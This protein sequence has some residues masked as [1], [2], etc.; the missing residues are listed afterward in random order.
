MSL[1]R[2]NPK[3]IDQTHIRMRALDELKPARRNARTH[4]ER[5]IEQIANSIT[6]FGFNNPILV[7]DQGNVMA[8]HGR[9]AAAELLGMAKVPT[10][11]ISHLSDDQKRA[12]IIA[13]NRIAEKSGWDDD[14]LRIEFQE[15]MDAD[16]GFELTD[17]GFEL[18]EIDV[19]LADSEAVEG[20]PADAVLPPVEQRLITSP[21]DLWRI[22]PH[23]I[24]CA[25]AL[26]A[27]SYERLLG[28][29]RAHVVFTDPPYN[30]KVSTIG[31]RGK[32][33]HRE[34]V[35]ASGE[36]SEAEY[37]RFLSTVCRHMATFSVGGALQFIC[38][39]WRHLM[40]LLRAGRIAYSELLNVCIWSKSGGGGMGSL[41]RSAHEEICVFK[42]GDNAHTNN[43]QLG[44]FGRN[45]TNVW[46]YPG[47]NSFQSGRQEALAQHPTV[48]PVAM[49]ADALLDSS[50]RG[51]IVLD[52]FIGSGTS[53]LAAHRTGRRCYG[54]EL[55]PA[56]ADVALRRVWNIVGIE[57]V[58]A[59]SGETF[60]Q[61]EAR[62][63]AQA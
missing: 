46:S 24:L 51:D 14:I 39:D 18:A 13:D 23:R 28:N 10:L 62:L 32:T 34:F 48:K 5:Q 63:A 20:D 41:Y 27:E 50:N 26:L 36:M 16:I 12:Y 7:D 37:T 59:A 57:P 11:Q 61:R 3:V 17:L 45:R 2:R 56:Y 40:E 4:S 47:L 21:G 33:K 30:V 15:L 60:S 29:E 58:C 38:I 53:A 44:R 19:L 1:M 8:G 43:I 54:M 31:G 52:P 55:D 22:G 35:M 6:A 9:L 49:V 25:N 42:N